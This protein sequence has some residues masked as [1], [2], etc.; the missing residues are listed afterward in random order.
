[1]KVAE[2]KV[3]QVRE[4][5]VCNYTTGAFVELMSKTELISAIERMEDIY[6][7]SDDE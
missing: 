7:E 5:V 1:M 6:E 3:E 4:Y 2:M